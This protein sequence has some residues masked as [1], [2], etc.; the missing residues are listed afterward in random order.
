VSTVAEPRLLTAEEFAALP[1]EGQKMELV[2]GRIV[3]VNMP[4][5]RHGKICATIARL[6]G[7]FAEEH[8]L[9]HVLSNDSGVITQRGPDSV[10]GMDVAFYSYERVPPGLLPEGYLK[11]VPDLSFEVRS[12]SDRW[13]KILAKMAEYLDASVPV[14]CIADQ[15]TA[16]VHVYQAD[17]PVRILTAE[18]ELQLPAPLNEWRVKVGAFFA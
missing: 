16:S 17:E 14:V 4:A 8:N 12:P 9:G 3:Y 7:N 5:A 2:R 15:L 1:D 13:P 6:L 18:Q 10:R 11:V